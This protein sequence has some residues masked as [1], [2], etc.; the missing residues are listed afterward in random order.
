MV[1]VLE[2]STK[3]NDSV[4]SEWLDW[5]RFESNVVY[6]G[7]MSSGAGI[8]MPWWGWVLIAMAVLIIIAMTT[9]IVVACRRKRKAGKL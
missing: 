4:N 6:C 2:Q 5:L 3:T 1:H 8:I 7:I 9:A